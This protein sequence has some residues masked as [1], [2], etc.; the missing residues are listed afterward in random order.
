MQ[1]T[2][3]PPEPTKTA[4]AARLLE[5]I[6]M[7]LVSEAI[8]VVAR[9]GVADLLALRPMTGNELAVATGADAD[10]VRRVMR[11]LAG[12]EVFSEI[13]ADR[14]ELA[15]AGEFL[16][17]NVA[18]SLHSAAMFF[19][20]DSGTN[21]L[22]LFLD[23]VKT[24]K[25]AVHHLS[26]GK[27][28][29]EWLA[30]D[31]ERTERFNSLMTSFANLHLTGVLEAYD[32]SYA[33]KMVDVGGGH[34]KNLV[35]ILQR[36]PR[37]QGV[38]FD[39]PHAFEGGKAAMARAGLAGRCEV[40]SGDFFASVPP[41]ADAYLLSRVIHD[42]N[43]EK[44]V[45]ILRTVRKVIDPR[46]KLVLLEAMLRPNSAGV[47][48][49]L[50]DLNMLLMTGGCERTEDEYSA[51]YRAAGFELTRTIATTSPTGTTVIEGRPI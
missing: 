40:V 23:S 29:F 13:S 50:S 51:L 3:C 35:E 30:S 36:Y 28:T 44:T 7:R 9:L 4:A 21:V 15:P 37:M 27:N 41:G 17:S 8:H 47:Y 42:W 20:G 5:L 46:G 48:P 31:P 24:G 18:G 16:R 49:L 11:A 25:S 26:G 33:A 10:S 19:G 45:T 14:F 1:S 6:Q 22:R 12:F 32:F 38:L 43:D 2:I 34:G 39:L